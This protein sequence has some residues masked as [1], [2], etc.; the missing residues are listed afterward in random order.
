MIIK[1]VGRFAAQSKRTIKRIRTMTIKTTLK[2]VVGLLGAL[3][4]L[5]GLASNALANQSDDVVLYLNDPL[6][7]AIAA[8]DEA[9]EL[10]WQESYTPYGQKTVLEDSFTPEGCG[11]ISEE[12]GFT[13]HTEDFKTD[14]VYMQQRYYD[15]TIGR[16][17]SVDPVGPKLGHP[18]T[19]N[20]Y[21]YAINNPY[22]FTDPNGESAVKLF[23]TTYKV[24]RKAFVQ[25]RKSGKLTAE[26]LKEIGLD[27]IAGIADD[28]N[29]LFGGNSSPL[30]RVKAAVDL[31]TGTDIGGKVPK[32]R[33]SRRPSQQQREDALARSQD[34][35]GIERCTYCDTPLDRRSGSPNSVEIDHKKA[36]ARGGET[37]DENLNAACR[38]CNR[39]K[40]AKE[41]GTEWIPP[42][43]R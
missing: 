13:G 14:L 10:C 31:I 34:T 1:I 12:R 36:Y 2:K 15:P 24:S 43:E 32:N 37:V 19:I 27:E 41:L 18:G 39:S 21:S 16:F 30:E 29:T 4:L 28:L 25:Y 7:S 8:F 9:G 35:D 20:R 38:T 42:N 11:T 5:P 6:G 17:L 23:T 22:S 26:N 33:T 40:G 3:V